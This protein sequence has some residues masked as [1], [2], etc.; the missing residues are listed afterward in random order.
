MNKQR[1]SGTIEN[2]L[3]IM[4]RLRDPVDGCP[5]DRE[6]SFE[7]IAPYTVEEA[8]EVADAVA[9]GDMGDLQDELGDLLLQVTYHARMAEEA[10]AFDF[11]AVVAAICAKMVRRHPHVFGGGTVENAEGQTRAWETLKEQEKLAVAES[12]LEG[13]PLALP[14]LTRAVKLGRRAARVGFD[15]PNLTGVRAKVEEELTELDEA[16]RLEDRSA[17]FQ[18]MGDVLFA[19]AN[20]C[21]HL[22]LDPEACVRG[23]NSRFEA[24]FRRVEERVSRTGSD[25]DGL[26]LDEMEAHWQ[27]VKQES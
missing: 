6:Q 8:Y 3:E 20:V 2:L 26:S 22:D 1:D 24:R 27:A 13:V 17:I 18:E 21:R 5:W 10:G 14:G 4:A 25:W 9:R 15:W 16:V 19:V 23:A 11:H 7:T 12:V